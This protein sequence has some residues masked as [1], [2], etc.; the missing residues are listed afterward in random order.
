MPSAPRP[1]SASRPSLTGRCGSRRSSRSPPPAALRG[2]VRLPDSGA[3]RPRPGRRLVAGR[4]LRPPQDPRGRRGPGERER[5]AARAARGADR[6]ARERDHAGADRA[7]AVGS[8]SGTARPPRAASRW[9][10]PPGAGTGSPAARREAADRGP[11]A[12]HGGRQ[13]GAGGRGRAAGRSPAGRARGAGRRRGALRRRAPGARRLRRSRGQAARRAG[14]ARLPASDRPAP[15]RAPRRRRW[16]RAAGPLARAA[17]G[18]GAD[19]RGLGRRGRARAAALR[20]DRLGQDGGLPRRRSRPRWRPA[21]PRSCSFPRSASRR[22]PWA[23]SPRASA[24]RS[25]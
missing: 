4:A 13:G 8:P 12:D 3:E 20:G 25:P 16:R 2:P 21:A 7:R 9:R 1:P 22:R 17:T 5:A 23:G 18:S 24:S 19:P 10:C 6:G 15:A 14:P 11:R